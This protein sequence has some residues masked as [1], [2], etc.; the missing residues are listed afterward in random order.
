MQAD[1]RAGADGASTDVVVI[2]AGIDALTCAAYLAKA[3]NDVMVLAP[4]AWVGDSI[5]TVDALGARANVGPTD[6]IMIR[7]TGVTAELGL[8]DYGLEY[9]NIDPSLVMMGWDNSPPWVL[10]TESERTLDLLRAVYPSAVDGYARYLRDALPVARMLLHMGSRQPTAQGGLSALRESK[11]SGWGLLRNWSKASAT[12]VL[13]EYFK[14]GPLKAPAVA[15]GVLANG[16][17]PAAPGT[18]LDALA[19]ALRHGIGAGRPQGGNAAIAEAL[20][21]CVEDYHGEIRCGVDVGAIRTVNGKVI[22][23]EL[24]DGEVID[25]PV[26]VGG[27]DPRQTVDLL[28]A[29]SPDQKKFGLGAHTDRRYRGSVAADGHRSRIDARVSQPPT[30]PKLAHTPFLNRTQTARATTVVSP[31][32]GD[33]RT[34][35]QF[36]QQGKI[37]ERP[38]MVIAAP[39]IADPSLVPVSGG[40]M[41]TIDVALTPYEVDGGWL[42]PSEPQR[43]LDLFC[44]ELAPDFAPSVEEWRCTTPLDFEREF[45]FDRGNESTYDAPISSAWRGKQRELTRYRF[46]IDG[47]FQTGPATFPGRGVW[48]TAGRNTAQVILATQT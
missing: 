17:D 48:A 27:G 41:L 44:D 28:R 47:L 4:N 11:G 34:A 14:L 5:T 29:G 15:L 6:H 22:G 13:D 31:S 2:G 20:A 43:W 33:L 18:G 39:S 38:A 32:V 10:H 1:E 16:H 36:A 23:V 46:P 9:I 3:G 12:E 25:A 19:Y 21:R 24:A 8:A 37:A 26:V 30:F 42:D 7:G 35:H 45:G 40:H